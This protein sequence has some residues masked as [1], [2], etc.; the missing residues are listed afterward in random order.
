MTPFRAFVSWLVLLAV[1]FLNGTVRQFAYPSTLGDFAARQ[2]ATGVGAAALGVTMWLLLRRWPVSSSRQAWAIGALWAGLTVV[3]EVALVRGGGHPWSD[4]LDQ[5]AIWR[6]SLWPLLVLWV[7]VAPATISG[8]QRARVAVGP[9]LRWAIVGW[10]ACGIVFALGRALFGMNAAVAIHL[11]A[12]PLIGATVTLL[13]WN[14]PRHPGV[15][16]TAATLSGGAAL[17]DAILVAPFF[18]RSFAM[19][20]SPAGTWIP[21]GLI[22]TASAATAALLSRPAARRDLL[23]WVAT[24]TEQVE[25]LPGDDLLSLGSPATHAIT[26]AAPPT[27]IWPWLAQMGFGRA[28]WYSH[29]LLDN[30]GHPSAEQVWPEWQAIAVGDPIPSS[31]GGRTYFEIMELREPAHLVFGFHMVWPFRSARWADPSTRFAQRAIWSFVLRPIGH[32]ATRLLARSGGVSQP[33]WL[34]AP[35]TAFFGIAHVVM[36]RKQL[37][38]I[39]RRAEQSPRVAPP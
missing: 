36:Q 11:L 7:L 26:V 15:L 34:W 39:R 20:G 5:Y 22:F 10:A 32:E 33:G 37:L 23:G 3:F 35:S 27:A 13:L 6:G 2:V 25:P 12:A 14:H 1:A 18:E 8:L 24:P 4:V 17:L 29:D 21:L 9:A 16:A 30:A 28:G 19:F 38:E 31:P